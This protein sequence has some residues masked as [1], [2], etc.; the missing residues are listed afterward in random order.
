MGCL[1]LLETGYIVDDLELQVS[2]VQMEI[3]LY[4]PWLEGFTI[5]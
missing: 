4:L 3:L 2:A 1:C 5:K